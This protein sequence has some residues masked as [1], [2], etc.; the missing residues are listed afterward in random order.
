MDIFNMSNWKTRECVVALAKEKGVA[1]NMN[2]VSFYIILLNYA[3]E[4]GSKD[5]NG[6]YIEATKE[7]IAEI[8]GFTLSR[9][10]HAF[11][12]LSSLGLLQ[13]VKRKKDEVG[14]EK[15]NL[16]GKYPNRTYFKCFDEREIT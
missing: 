8:T 5:E 16:R 15:R 7:K 10:L 4:N 9:S 12:K 13:S 1:V 11:D 3:K 2:D 6:L 14:P